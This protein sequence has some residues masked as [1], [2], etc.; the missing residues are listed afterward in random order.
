MTV[1]ALR[2][3]GHDVKIIRGTPDQ[4]SADPDVWA[5]ALAES[6]AL[7]TTDKGFTKYR[8]EP[9]DGILVV[10]LRQPNGQDPSSR[11]AR[12]Q[13]LSG[14]GMDEFARRRARH[15]MSTS[16]GGGERSQ[17]NKRT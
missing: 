4:G 12:H 6:R 8:S 11:H 9:H 16:R 2:A 14:S 3:L 13:A 15:I 10:R 1:E 5:L 17:E 7:I